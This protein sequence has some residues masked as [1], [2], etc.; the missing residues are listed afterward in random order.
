MEWLISANPTI[1]NYSGSLKKHGSIDW[2]QGRIKYN[3]NDIIYIYCTSPIKKIQYKCKIVKINVHYS[4]IRNDFDYW[5]NINGYL[6]AL[7]GLYIHLVL[8]EYVDIEALDL[9]NLQKHGLKR[10]PQ[11]PMKL[12]RELSKYINI[13]FNDLSSDTIESSSDLYR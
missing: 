6:K 12:N 7:N 1:Y 4:K 11:G 8:L 2:R 9:S 10:A 5:F 3:L 13:I